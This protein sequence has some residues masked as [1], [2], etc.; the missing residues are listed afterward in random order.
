MCSECL[1]STHSTLMQVRQERLTHRPLQRALPGPH[2]ASDRRVVLRALD[3]P[4]PRRR[5]AARRA[6]GGRGLPRAARHHGRRARGGREVRA[7]AENKNKKQQAGPAFERGAAIVV[8]MG[9]GLRPRAPPALW[10]RAGTGRALSA[11]RC[12]PRRYEAAS[13]LVLD[14][15]KDG[16]IEPVDASPSSFIT[17][18][19]TIG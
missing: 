3:A 9:L 11:G 1:V 13:T 4:P 18:G 16:E 7:A 19:P 8:L 5:R 12:G 17:D 10:P 2:P 6:G 14:T 15:S